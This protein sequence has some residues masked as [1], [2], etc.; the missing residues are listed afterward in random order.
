LRE[1]G[2]KPFGSKKLATARNATFPPTT[3]V[4]AQSPVRGTGRNENREKNGSD[5]QNLG[6]VGRIANRKRVRDENRREVAKE[7]ST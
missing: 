5:E 2:R 6:E 3:W 4:V 1:R 7:S